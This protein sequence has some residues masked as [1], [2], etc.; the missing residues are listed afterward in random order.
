MITTVTNPRYG[1]LVIGPP[2]SGKTTYCSAMYEFL[3]KIGRHV[4]VINLDPAND[5]NR[6]NP[7]HVC[8]SELTSSTVNVSKSKSIGPNAAILDCFDR[9]ASPDGTDWFIN[10]IKEFDESFY[11]LIDCPGQVELYSNHNAMRKLLDALQKSNQLDVRLCL[12]NLADSLYCSQP[13][14]FI[15]LVLVT[16][17]FM[18][19]MELPTVNVLTKLDLLKNCNPHF[20]AELYTDVLDLKKL[21]LNDESFELYPNCTDPDKFNS[22]KLGNTLCD[23]IQDYSLVC[24]SGLDIKNRQSMVKLIAEIDRAIGFVHCKKCKKSVS[25]VELMSSACRP[26][27]HRRY[28][29]NLFDHYRDI[30]SCEETQ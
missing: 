17:N 20:A 29:N 24:F 2:G 10:R 28:V 21:L 13:Q 9:L 22:T 14:T 11:L 15:S 23:I 4:L 30:E 27:L 5:Y 18:L 19:Y 1:Q 12:V 8:L 7:C 26:E 3:T 16:L 6:P 25:A